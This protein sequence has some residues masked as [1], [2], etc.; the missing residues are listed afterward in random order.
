MINN[1]RNAVID[2]K[3]GLL[4]GYFVAGYPEGNSFLEIVKESD[5]AGI[6]IFEIG[7]PSADP[8]AD[9]ATIKNAH[10]KVDKMEA[11]KIE[12]WEKIRKVTLKPIWIMAYKKDLIDTDIYMGLAKEGLVDAIVI[13]DCTPEERKQIS[14]N[15]EKYGVE[16]LGFANPDMK[17]DEWRYSFENFKIVYL[18]LYTGPTGLSVE[19][20]QH[21][22]LFDY[23]KGYSEVKCFAGFG[24]KTPEKATKLIN[25]GFAGVIIGTAIIANLDIS[26]DK[27]Y[28][29]ISEIKTA[30]EVR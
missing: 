19:N 3:N 16:V 18:Q 13:P 12:Y 15:T 28:S 4:V 8:Y 23:S 7:F 17:E 2:E 24:I 5:K 20:D 27:L 26:T 1:N 11:T 30:I 9:G 10:E 14:V 21:H 29:Y 6:D 22:K 25:E